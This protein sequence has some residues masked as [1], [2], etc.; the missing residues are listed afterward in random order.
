MRR[1]G[2]T[3]PRAGPPGLVPN[4]PRFFS[5]DETGPRKV[6]CVPRYPRDNVPATL[7]LIACRA[8]SPAQPAPSRNL[9]TQPTP[10]PARPHLFQGDGERPFSG[11]AP[12]GRWHTHSSSQRSRL[13]S[14]HSAHPIAWT[15]RSGAF[16]APAPSVLSLRPLRAELREHPDPRAGPLAS[17]VRGRLPLDAALASFA[18]VFL[19]PGARHGFVPRAFRPR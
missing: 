14:R 15:G 9:N 6:P 7:R 12:A 5:F 8:R 19:P 4:S 10:R 11:I 2:S 1:R 13:K 17:F 3:S 16:A 18:H